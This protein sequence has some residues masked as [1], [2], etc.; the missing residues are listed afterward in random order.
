MAITRQQAE[1]VVARVVRDIFRRYAATRPDL[2]RP[3]VRGLVAEAK[4]DGRPAARRALRAIMWE[5]YTDAFP[6]RTDR[7]EFRKWLQ[8]FLH[9]RAQAGPIPTPNAEAEDLEL[10]D[11]VAPTPTD[12]VN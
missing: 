12:V 8:S 4:A 11:A 1:T 9:T 2:I 3:I 7:R 10:D 5:L 6:G